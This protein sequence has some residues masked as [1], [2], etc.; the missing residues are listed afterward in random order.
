MD[1]S[2]PGF[3]VHHQL[4]E[5][6]QTHI[7]QVGDAIQPSHPLLSPS[8]PD[9]QGPAWGIPPVAKVMRQEAWHTQRCD[10]AS[11]APLGFSWTSTPKNQS[12][13]ALLYCAFHSSDITGA[14]PD[15][16]SLE[17]INLELQLAS[18]IWK[19]CLSSN[20]SNGSL[21]CL[22][23][24]PLLLQLVILPHNRERHAA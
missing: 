11:G 24:S 13:P 22:T 19:E 15:H 5:L 18:C 9:C 21:T 10:L 14:I 17:K 6:A 8:I 23:E 7:H 2:I 3:P 12:L 16:L 20:P 4:L 1:C